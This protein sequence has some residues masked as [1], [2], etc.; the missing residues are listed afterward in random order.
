MALV[1]KEKYLLRGYYERITL[2]KTYTLLLYNTTLFGGYS[3]L[4]TS[5]V[6]CG[7][8]LLTS[9]TPSC[10]RRLHKQG[11]GRHF[12]TLHQPDRDGN[13]KL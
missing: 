5:N 4:L 6:I 10:E 9:T 8:M 1:E 7:G 13:P 2:R 3:A 11:R 12:H